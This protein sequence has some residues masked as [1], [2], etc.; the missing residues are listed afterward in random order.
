VK[1]LSIE[2]ASMTAEATFS[3]SPVCI[4]DQAGR[5]QPYV[6]LE[7]APADALF[8]PEQAR[9]AAARLS[10]FADQ[11]EAYTAS[12]RAQGAEVLALLQTQGRA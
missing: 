3:L 1:K 10:A 12:L 6:R 5:L 2:P 7:G 4:P 9:H 11:A 8:T